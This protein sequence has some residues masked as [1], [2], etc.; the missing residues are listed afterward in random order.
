[1]FWIGI[2]RSFMLE[3]QNVCH[4]PISVPRFV[5]V[6]TNV[7]Y[8][9]VTICS[10]IERRY[11]AK[12][13]GR[14]APL[15]AYPILTCCLFTS[16]S[17]SNLSLNYINYPT[18]VVFRSCK[19]IPTMLIA[20]IMNKSVFSSS[21]YLS[22]VGISL[23]LIMFT[24]ADWKTSPSFNPTGIALVSLSVCADSILP[25]FQ[26]KIFSSG[27]SRLEVTVYTN[28]LVLIAMTTTTL[29]SGD[30][31][32][33]LKLMRSDRRI[34]NYI[35][36]YT[37]VAYIAISIYMQIVKRYGG[38]AAVLVTTARKALTIIL[39]FCLFP[40]AFS[41]LYVFGSI[42]VLGGLSYTS[43]LKQKQQKAVT[44]IKSS[45]TVDIEQCKEPLIHQ[46]WTP[47][48]SISYYKKKLL[49]MSI[50]FYFYSDDFD[51]CHEVTIW[52]YGS[53]MSSEHRSYFR[54]FLTSS[55][56]YAIELYVHL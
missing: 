43:L 35:T 45:A 50:I 33:T 21:E 4:W 10:S 19:L 41:W 30:L 36:V 7:E 11:I 29:W 40:K 26:Q 1:M 17:L 37:F 54:P 27:A 13:T 53:R 5:C 48:N 12:E 20:T 49:A 24:T 31:M 42:L 25:N 16:A 46:K 8:F 2:D 23:G 14:V 9:R 39:S 34:F 18:R 28:I 55:S 38:V 51:R 32:G 44:V 52:I 15:S 47:T 6:Y 3:L 22:A 56:S